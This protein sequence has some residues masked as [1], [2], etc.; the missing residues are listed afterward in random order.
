MTA[1]K[2]SSTSATQCNILCVLQG[3]FS[4]CKVQ[5]TNFNTLHH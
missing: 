3:N 2:L 1:A 5:L 4:M